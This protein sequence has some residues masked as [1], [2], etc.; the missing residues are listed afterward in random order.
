MKITKTK[1]DIIIDETIDD[2]VMHANFIRLKSDGLIV[3]D[4]PY[5]QIESILIVGSNT[6]I[7]GRLI[8]VCSEFQIPIHVITNQHKHYGSLYFAVHK[9]IQNRI[10]QYKV[11]TDNK[12]SMYIAKVLL[13]HKLLTQSLV[14]IDIAKGIKSLENKTTKQQLLGVE[15]KAASI[16]WSFLPNLFNNYTSSNFT[17]TKREKYPCIDPIN[18]ILSLSYGL[19]ATQ[20]QSSLTIKG[21]DP[22]Y[23][24]LHIANDS[25]PAMVY[26]LMEVYRV[27]IVDMWVIELFNSGFFDKSDFIFTKEGVC[28]LTPSKKNDFFS[29]WYKRLKFKKFSTNFGSV[30][31]LEFIQLNTSYMIEFLTKINNNKVRNT[32]RSDLFSKYLIDFTNINEFKD[33]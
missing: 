32:G 24:V 19:L 12:W 26:D 2:V 31:L 23:G 30:T 27:L 18:S 16:Y 14:N 29:L 6:T 21:L 1:T 5:Q 20:C 3:A 10:L 9:N 11:F 33:L 22:Y 25:R 13:H 4:I 15:G 7:T 8:K 28:T 17:F